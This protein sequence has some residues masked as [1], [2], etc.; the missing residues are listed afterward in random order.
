MPEERHYKTKKIVVEFSSLSGSVGSV[1]FDF[2]LIV[3]SA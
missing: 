3:S 2:L 1:E